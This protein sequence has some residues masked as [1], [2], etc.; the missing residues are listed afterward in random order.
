VISLL[1]FSIVSVN[2]K[3]KQWSKKVVRDKLT[4]FSN[5][6]AKYHIQMQCKQ[7]TRFVWHWSIDFIINTPKQ[8]IA[9]LLN[10]APRCTHSS[11]KY[12]AQL[13]IVAQQNRNPWDIVNKS[14][15]S[16]HHATNYH[17]T[18]YTE[19]AIVY[20]VIYNSQ[21]TVIDF[22]HTSLALLE[23]ENDCPQGIDQ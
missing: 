6:Y 3:Q 11:T 8:L 22:S 18:Q 5:Y 2:N 4:T 17:C 1:L 10:N 15:P 23:L 7:R 12:F 20:P 13:L 9:R 19:M 14:C 16:I 21:Y